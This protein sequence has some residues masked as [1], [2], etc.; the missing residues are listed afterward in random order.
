MRSRLHSQ[1][2]NVCDQ[3]M[4]LGGSLVELLVSSLIA[5]IVVSGLQATIATT[6]RSVPSSD[7][8]ASTTLLTS[9][10][11]DRLVTELE[12]AIYV[13]ERSATTF[14]FIVP[15]RDNDGI[16]ER[17]R[18]AWTG[19]PGGPLTRQ[20]N[21]GTIVTLASQVNLFS[22]TPAFK[23][24]AEMYPSVGVEDATESLLIDNY[25][26]SGLQDNNITSFTWFGQY[27]TMTL[28]AN[29]YA[30]RPTRLQIMAK[31]NS[32]PGT[33]S[34]QLRPATAN[35]TPSSTVFEQYSLID[36]T[37]T[38]SYAWQSLNYNSLAPISSGGSIALALQQQ[39]GTNSGTFQQC[40][41]FPGLLKT[42]SSGVSWTYDSGKCLVSRLY[43]KL[44]R[45]SGTQSVN[46]NYLTSLD[47]GLR[48]TATSPLQ[49]S[50]AAFLNHPE[51]LSD[52]WE[53]K[54]DKNPTTV[55]VNGDTLGDWVVNGSGLFNMS[56]I[57]NGIW[58]ASSTQLNTNPAK[59]FTKTTLVDLRF[60]N[61][62]VGGNGATFSV[63]ALRTNS[64]CAPISA[65]LIKQPDGTQTLTLATKTSDS[66]TKTLIRIPGLPSQL[67][68]VHLIIA[69]I[70]SSVSISV[71]AVPYG[72]FKVSP[73]ASS[74]GNRFASIGASAT[75]AEFSYARI[76]VLEN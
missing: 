7:G 24:V 48:M 63:N 66:I 12:T 47:I 70:T 40:D 73:F 75:T 68:L 25:G 34:V 41:A 76:R 64:I 14:G 6:M 36:S 10:I 42:T 19:A 49:K 43:G 37:M 65:S 13:T 57:S 71:N 32:V 3:R 33:T 54:F 72:T 15:D 27:F 16:D 56:L 28:P 4:R 38:S 62:G 58:Q 53:L 26:T 8:V 50:T 17:I 74:D 45:S 29:S 52:Y 67:V 55:D 22:L 31:K 46:S 9:Q 21:G 61:T 59:D 2:V 60:R 39:T 11:A 30:W 44:I 35:L 18:Y 23:S 5:G 51:L 1:D 69:P 20:Y